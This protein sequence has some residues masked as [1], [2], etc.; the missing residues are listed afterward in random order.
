MRPDEVPSLAG[1]GSASARRNGEQVD[2]RTDG[3][4]QQPRERVGSKRERDLKQKSHEERRLERRVEWE[5]AGVRQPFEMLLEGEDRKWE[6]REAPRR[7][8]GHS[9]FAIAHDAAELARQSY[10]EQRA[11]NG[12][13]QGEIGEVRM[14][15]DRQRMAPLVLVERHKAIGKR[16]RGL[17]PDHRE[18][19]H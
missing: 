8:P 4:E 13:N 6:S 15:R 17:R 18:R 19:N 10:E 14:A 7:R 12:E 3:S 11:A 1:R 16:V 2:K 5:G 9:S